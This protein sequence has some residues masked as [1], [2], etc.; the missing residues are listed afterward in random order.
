M[1]VKLTESQLRAFI[2]EEIGRNYHTIDTDPYTWKD[3]SDVSVEIHPSVENNKWTAEVECLSD[4]SLSTGLH[5][6]EDEQSAEHW[7]RVV[8]D[9]IMRKTI[10]QDL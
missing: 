8:A 6:F 4:P 7:A 1:S 3:Y 5:S 2:R 9:K 10:S